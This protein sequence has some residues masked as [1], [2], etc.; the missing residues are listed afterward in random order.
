MY[1]NVGKLYWLFAESQGLR[2]TKNA[3]R[4]IH[5]FSKIHTAMEFAIK[6]GNADDSYG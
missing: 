4:V 5:E 6:R 3:I 2:L 1:T